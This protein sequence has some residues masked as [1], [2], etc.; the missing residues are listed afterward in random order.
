MKQDFPRFGIKLLCRLFGKTRHAY[1]DHQWRSQ[2]LGLKDELVLQ[3]VPDIRKKQNRIGTLKLHYMLQQPLEQHGIKIG[4]DY[5]FELMREHGL[6][7]RN[8][9]RKVVT[10]NSRHWMHKYNNLI[11][12]LLI[13][14][15]EQVWVSDITYIRLRKQWGYLS[16]LT[17]AYSKKIM[18][19]AFRKDLS[20]QG[21]ID[22][23]E[24]AI[25][26]RKYPQN[27]LIHHSDRGSQYCSKGYVDLLTD[28]NIAV[29]MTENGDP[30]ENAIAERVNGIL[31]AEF[32]LYG[33][34]TGLRETTG[35]I[36]DN[37]QT[38]NQV[39]PHASCDYLTPEQAHLQHGELK[40]RWKPKKYKTKNTTCITPTGITN[41]H[42]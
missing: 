25:A 38:Y 2:D 35:K 10:T 11:K 9:K 17:D 7:I 14:G 13:N 40:K 42:V 16:L 8:R 3:H 37:I 36:R 18:G 20:A 1:Y 23:L 5:L 19:W 15:P 26:D 33:A 4:R 27:R 6:H 24:M 32:D 22:A 39:R 31:K 41:L 28:G 30:Y 34:Q 21:C 29:S 12:E